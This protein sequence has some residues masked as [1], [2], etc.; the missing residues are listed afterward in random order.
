MSQ[1]NVEFVQSLY[2]AFL[3]GDIAALIQGAAPDVHWEIA[4]RRDD[5][6]LF[7]VRKGHAG[8][9]DFFSSLPQLQDTIA[10]TPKEFYASGDKVFVLGHYAWTIRKSGRKVAS[11]WAHVFTIGDGKVTRFHEFT[12]TAQYAGAHR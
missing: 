5:Y 8:M 10:F 2:A 11:D 1:A 3:R 6:P 7:G 12:D 4:G 9:Q